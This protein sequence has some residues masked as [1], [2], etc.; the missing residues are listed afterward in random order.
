MR[1]YE[2]KI[3]DFKRLKK[4]VDEKYQKAIEKAEK[5]R[6]EAIAA[7]LKLFYKEI[8]G[9]ELRIDPKAKAKNC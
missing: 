7:P 8:K 3:A 5:D 1:G 4:A 9:K 2:I 6:I